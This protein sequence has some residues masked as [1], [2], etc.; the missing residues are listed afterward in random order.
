MSS[1]LMLAFWALGLRSA[2]IWGVAMTFLS[3]VPML[4]AFLVWVPA[5][6]YLALLL[7]LVHLARLAGHEA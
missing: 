4:G 1:R 3:M 7:P 5:A 2:I 6:I